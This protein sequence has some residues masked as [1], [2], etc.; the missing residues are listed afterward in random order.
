MSTRMSHAEPD[1]S[2]VV[3]RAH[4]EDLTDSPDPPPPLLT[5]GPPPLALSPQSPNVPYIFITMPSTPPQLT[6]YGSD[7]SST[8]TSTPLPS[9]RPL[10]TVPHPHFARP[11]AFSS[12]PT[13]SPLPAPLPPVS[14]PSPL[15]PV[16]FHHR[17]EPL[18]PSP[19]STASPSLSESQLILGIASKQKRQQRRL[20]SSCVALTLLS[21]LTIIAFVGAVYYL[22]HGVHPTLGT[23]VVQ[24]GMI[25]DGAVTGPKLAAAAVSTDALDPHVTSLLLNFNAT[26]RQSLSMLPVPGVGLVDSPGTR[27]FNVNPDSSSLVVTTTG[28]SVAPGGI[29][30]IHLAPAAVT[31]TQVSTHA[32]TSDKLA[33]NAVTTSQ[34]GADVKAALGAIN[35][36]ATA[37][38]SVL[39]YAGI[40]MT[41]VGNEIN[42]L[43]D[44]GYLS[45]SNAAQLTVTPHSLNASMFAPSSI[46]ASSLAPTVRSLIP[47]AGAGLTSSY[48]PFNSTLFTV[49]TEDSSIHM[50]A[51]AL[52]LGVLTSQ[53]LAVGAVTIGELGSDVWGELDGLNETSSQ[54]LQWSIEL[55]VSQ[56]FIQQQLLSA[57]GLD[58]SD[59]VALASMS[60]TQL[61][62]AIQRINA[63]TFSALTAVNTSTYQLKSLL[64]FDVQQLQQDITSTYQDL[65]SQLPVAGQGLSLTTSPS[66]LKVNA[67]SRYFTFTGETLGLLPGSIDASVLA[68]GAVTGLNIADEAV[69]TTAFADG[70]VHLSHF[71]SNLSQ[72]LRVMSAS[73]TTNTSI[74]ILGK[75]GSPITITRPAGGDLSIAAGADSS[76]TVVAST[77][78]NAIQLTELGGVDVLATHLAL[79]STSGGSVRLIGQTVAVSAVNV[80]LTVSSTAASL[81]LTTVNATLAG[82]TTTLSAETVLLQGASINLTAPHVT[83]A[84]PVHYVPITV[85]LSS[86]TTQY[87]IDMSSL[88]STVV[89]LSGGGP[90]LLLTFTGCSDLYAG[91]SVSVY[92]DL[93]TAP[94]ITVPSSSCSRSASVSVSPLS[95]LTVT[96]AGLYQSSPFYD[97]QQSEQPSGGLPLPSS[98]QVISSVVNGVALTSTAVGV[99]EL[100]FI[101]YNNVN[102][103]MSFSLSSS[104]FKEGSTA[105]LLTAISSGETNT[106][107]ASDRMTPVWVVGGQV[108]DPVGGVVTVTMVNVGDPLFAGASQLLQ[109]LYQIV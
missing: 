1:I 105:L 78:N 49:A 62:N 33:V 3:E 30:S 15:Y 67:D 12:V 96:C 17:P 35:A 80:S 5:L 58:E 51:G 63:T 54:A 109:F 106:V 74:L 21:L 7:L 93:T 29:Q 69:T 31:S 85:N 8:R 56:S 107:Y 28:L 24:S 82:I 102:P 84:S 89:R 43:L 73:N 57:L 52:S 64:A 60:S 37:A 98:I 47:Q 44:G 39:P 103:V 99:V 65:S 70:A 45:L 81:N 32:V 18:I 92:N 91:S 72:V 25:E 46:S 4:E 41:V 77:G 19:I 36:T 88:N 100:S 108:L 20:Y 104:L 71:A 10:T 95:R 59:E 16:A 42:L 34:L 94:F 27:T 79:A 97:C 23:G 66:Q 75:R 83:I 13:D 76:L 40:G 22:D 11:P 26:Y 50:T 9:S 14:S 38:F 90:P 48:S 68:P 55:A 86:N 101:P 2:D 6:S 61:L 87:Q 53:H